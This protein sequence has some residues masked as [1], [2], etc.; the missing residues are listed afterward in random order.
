M[1]K[2]ILLL[3]LLAFTKTFAQTIS[4][5]ENVVKTDSILESY[6]NSQEPGM[7]IGIVHNGKIIYQNS[8]GVANLSNKYAATDSTAFNIASVSKQFTALLALKAEEE[9]KLS[10]Q[11]DITL[12]LPELESL[13]HKITIEQL[14]NHTHGLPNYSDL[15]EMIGF[16][17]TTPISNEQAVKTMLSTEQVN[18]EAGTQYQY[19]NSGFMLLAEILKRIYQKPFP[20]VIKEKIFEP[21]NMTQTSVIDN[22]NTIVSNKAI[23]Y[24]KNESTYIE[25]PNRQMECGSSNIHTTLTDLIKWVINFQNPKVG[26]QNQI[27]RLITKTVS[28]SKKSDLSYGLGLFTETYNGLK[29]V[30]HGGGTGGYRAYILHVPVH[31]FSIVTLGNQ[32]SFDGLLIVQDLLEL[33]LKD[34][35]VEPLH[36]KKSYTEEELR[37]FE[38]VY[39]VH[40][41]QYW[42]IESDG[43]NLYCNGDSKPLPLIGDEKFKWFYRPTSYLTFYPNSM[44]WRIADF[45][46]HCEKVNLNP[47][48]LSKKELE[49]YVG[50]YK[51]EE[52][53]T[54]YELLIIENNL[55]ARHLTNGDIAL[56]PLSENSFYAAYPLG[57]L[58]FQINLKGNINGFVLSGQNIDNIKFIKLK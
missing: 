54:F 17:L 34:Y 58:D 31:N 56:Y 52:F 49:K 15:I 45:N 16:G 1:N 5:S 24:A 39:K 10:L 3:V 14:A 9:G 30:F 50:V 13:P 40:P 38:G 22:P 37:N 25:H 42:T 33:Y 26:T 11:D 23:A 44:D 41:G 53:N 46:Y 4:V 43:K 35:L 21:L 6:C 48:I 36:T 29:T 28:L 47:P 27:N 57:E 51:N 32:E 19:G 2:I 7:S 12:Y 8:I 18:F 20:L 55:L